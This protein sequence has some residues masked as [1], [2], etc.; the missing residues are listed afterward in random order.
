MSPALLCPFPAALL[1]RLVWV[2]SSRSLSRPRPPVAASGEFPR[3]RAAVIRSRL[4]LSCPGACQRP[5]PG[6][7]GLPLLP[8]PPLGSRRGPWPGF[9][10]LVVRLLSGSFALSPS[11]SCPA[12]RPPLGLARPGAGPCRP[13]AAGRPRGRRLR[14]PSCLARSP[15]SRP[16]R[17]LVGPSVAG[18]LA[19]P[20]VGPAVDLS[21]SV[22]ILDAGHRSAESRKRRQPS[23]VRRSATGT[24]CSAWDAAGGGA[25][26][27][28][29]RNPCHS[30]YYIQPHQATDI[31]PPNALPPLIPDRAFV[32]RRHSPSR[33]SPP[34]PG[35]SVARC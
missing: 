5:Q 26:T 1:W 32:A 19:L 25:G 7:S 18:R 34:Y 20:P 14:T 3:S 22:M 11:C 6:L 2:S 27:P 8:R 33:P 16:R 35:N 13:R 4:Q 30:P 28:K 31:D 23:A 21:S 10:G 29:G 15:P 9:A 17:S 24:N 12:V